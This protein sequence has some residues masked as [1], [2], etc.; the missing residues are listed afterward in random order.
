MV[1]VAVQWQREKVQTTMDA[2]EVQQMTALFQRMAQAAQ[3]DPETAAQVR[4]ALAESGLLDVFGTGETLDIV[5]LLYAGGEAAVRLRLRDLT[6]A[7]LRQI[8]ATHQY[9][10][11]KESARWR[12]AAKFIDLIVTRAQAQLEEEQAAAEAQQAPLTAA[13]WML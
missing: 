10:P 9:D 1:A 12:S 5:E 3:A 2:R 13:S 11:E 6:L 4:E 8:V 7:Q